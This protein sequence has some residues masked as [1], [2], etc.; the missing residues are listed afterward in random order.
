MK[1]ISLDVLKNPI[2]DISTK[3][4]ATDRYI[5][6]EEARNIA[7]LADHEVEEMKRTT[8]LVNELITQEIGRVGLIPE[9]GKVEFGFDEGRNLML[10]D[11]LG[12]PDEC[13]FTFADLP[14]SKE[15]AR[16]FYRHTPWYEEVEE[17]KKKHRVRWKE[18]VRATPP[19]LPYRLAELI[20]LLY[21]AC[22]NEITQKQC[23][24]APSLREILSEIKEGLG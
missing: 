1:S 11:V 13:R 6:W 7:G 17:A 23:F 21:Q 5:G 24:V 15:V 14:V 20:S 4:E 10:V 12:T 8:L 18:L 3:L 2:L 16:I 22:C 19:P 9:D